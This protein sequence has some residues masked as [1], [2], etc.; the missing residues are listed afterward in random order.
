MAEEEDDSQKTE[1]PSGRKLE[2]GRRRGQVAQSSE[3]ANWGILTAGA[4]LVL[5]A[6]PWSMRGI[7]RLSLPFL[8]SPGQISADLYR[9]HLLLA[10]LAWAL[11]AALWPVFLFLV[12]AAFAIHLAQTGLVWAVDRFELDWSRLSPLKGLRR[13]VSLRTLVEF[14]KGVA[15]IAVVGGIISFLAFPLLKDVELLPAMSLGAVLDRSEAV[16][17]RVA[18]AALAVLTVIAGLD[19]LYQRFAFLRQMRMTKHEVKEEH[20]QTEGDPHVKARIRT[21]RRERARQRMMA[22]VPK[23]TVVITNPTHYAV[24]LAYEMEKMEAPKLVAKGADFLALRIR[25]VA[26]ENDVPVVENPPLARA[27]YANVELDEE[28]PVEHYKAVAEVIGF[29]MRLKGKLH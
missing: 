29:V 2:R 22:A 6:A 24:A 3:V 25:E 10:D 12:V 13:L 1:D 15:K 11:L 21:L 19:F 5:F 9:L 27:L 18:A 17:L 23:A 16:V 28:I 4:M 8:E 26:E 20:K 7:A 14:V